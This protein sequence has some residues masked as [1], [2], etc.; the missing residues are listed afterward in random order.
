[1]YHTQ[2][3]DF[4]RLYNYISI[5]I[6]PLLFSRVSKPGFTGSDF[7][8]KKRFSKGWCQMTHGVATLTKYVVWKP[9]STN[10]DQACLTFDLWGLIGLGEWMLSDNADQRFHSQ[11]NSIIYEITIHFCSI[12]PMLLIELILYT[13]LINIWFKCQLRNFKHMF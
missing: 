4:R 1:M 13:K 3:F 12:L 9:N 6:R 11:R 10:P 5:E 8:E 2:Q 7:F